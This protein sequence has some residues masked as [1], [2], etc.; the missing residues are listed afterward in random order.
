MCDSL[1]LCPAVTPDQVDAG[2]ATTASFQDWLV[3]I[4]LTNQLWE[5]GILCGEA[6]HFAQLHATVAVGGTSWPFDTHARADT[7]GN[8]EVGVMC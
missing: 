5:V 6:T 7:H 4:E 2:E 1:A 8:A 3:T